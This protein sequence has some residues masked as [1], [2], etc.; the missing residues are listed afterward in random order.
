V[1][2][3]PSG[4]RIET[5]VETGST[6]ADLV[7]RASVGEPSGL[8]LRTGH[9]TAGRGR[10]ERRWDAPAGANLLFSVLLRP[11]WSAD[12]LPLATSC[13]AVSLVDALEPLLGSGPVAAVKWPNDVLLV[14]R[15]S[16]APAGT[17]VGKLAGILAEL[18]GGGT[19]G[20]S[21]GASDGPSGSGPAVVVGMGVNVAW[22]APG[23]EAPPGAVSLAG[24]G[25]D[26]D[27]AALLDDVLAAFAGHLSTLGDPGGPEKLRMA[28]LARSATIGRAVRV[29]RDGT[30]LVGT[31][32]DVGAEGALVVEVAD[33]SRVEVLAGDVV[34]LRTD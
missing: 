10:L 14:D 6:N 30:D 16:E 33:G 34:H 8:V 22:P 20:L 18:V 7:Q 27:P 25:V 3:T 12:R 26:V 17:P 19:V 13:M 24:V 31:A 5:V 28:H 2:S 4:F 11:D 9:Q 23:D 29:E 32:V 15:S 21:D 1:P